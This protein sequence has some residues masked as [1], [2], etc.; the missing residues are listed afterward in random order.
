MLKAPIKE[1]EMLNLQAY[2]TSCKGSSALVAALTRNLTAEV[3]HYTGQ[4][5]VAVFNDC[6]KFFDTI[7]IEELISQATSALFPLPA[8]MYAFSVHFSSRTIQFQNYCSTPMP[9][10]CLQP[11][12]LENMEAVDLNK[13][14][15]IPSSL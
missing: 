7:N 11:G 8:L 14:L 5:S 10:R 4:K 2:D 12:V 15:H 9:V 6:L 3:A 1:W 13:L